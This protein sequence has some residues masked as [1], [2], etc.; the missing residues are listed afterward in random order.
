MTGEDMHQAQTELAMFGILQPMMGD[1]TEDMPDLS[2]LRK[3]NPFT[4]QIKIYD[5]EELIS[6][7]F[8][9]EPNTICKHAKD[10]HFN[11]I[12]GQHVLASVNKN[13]TVF[14]TVSAKVICNLDIKSREMASSMVSESQRRL[15][16]GTYV[17][18]LF[19]FALPGY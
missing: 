18:S 12:R 11:T 6:A 5:I 1:V 13:V 3:N 7:C 4:L 17:D 14:D 2:M 15:F 16:I 19:I 9:K 10:A 8:K